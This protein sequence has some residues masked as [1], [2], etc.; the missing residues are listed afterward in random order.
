VFS[1][2]HRARVGKAAKGA[3]FPVLCPHGPALGTKPSMKNPQP[4]CLGGSSSDGTV[5]G[6]GDRGPGP[7][8]SPIRVAGAGPNDHGPAPEVLL[9][10]GQHKVVDFI[11]EAFLA[12]QG[13]TGP[14]ARKSTLAPTICAVPPQTREFRALFLPLCNCGRAGVFPG[15]PGKLRLEAPGQFW[16]A[17]CG[18]P[19]AIFAGHG[20]PASQLP[21]RQ[22][23]EN[24]L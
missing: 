12:P 9:Q 3:V 4:A 5:E 18:P 1:P 16:L 2:G 23:R 21:P 14:R 17:A 15:P 8:K 20:P 13:I 7:D 6:P 11:L 10:N 22:F 19:G 24:S